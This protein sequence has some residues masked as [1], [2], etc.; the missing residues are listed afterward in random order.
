MSTEN[1]DD[2]SQSADDDGAG[3]TKDV[4]VNVNVSASSDAKDDD[5]LSKKDTSKFTAEQ[6]DD[7]IEK[8]KDENARRRIANKKAT[9]AQAARQTEFDEM[10][11]KLDE[12][13]TKAADDAKKKKEADL[14]EKSE[15]EQLRI[16]LTDLETTMKEKD[17]ELTAL[18]SETTKKDRDLL[19]ASREN[20][21]DRLVRSFNFEFAS[22]FERNGFVGDLL[23]T[24]EDGTFAKNDEE[25]ILEVNSLIKARGGKAPPHT[26]GAGPKSKMQDTPLSQEVQTLLK[27]PNL[28]DEERARL[29]EVIGLIE[30]A[31]KTGAATV[32]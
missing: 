11:S 12:L 26:P 13:T 30:E 20:M 9:D 15:I 22:D 4:N 21:I 14:A 8:L 28:N 27:K 5:D 29:T 3:G 6:K 24:G 1:Q 2:K 17:T 23:K 10:K 32:G 19:K 31:Q 25:V 18:K 16:R 7:Y